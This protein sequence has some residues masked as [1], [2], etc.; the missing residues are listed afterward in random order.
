MQILISG[1]CTKLLSQLHVTLQNNT[2]VSI[3]LLIQ[4]TRNYILKMSTIRQLI[5]QCSTPFGNNCIKIF[6][7]TTHHYVVPLDREW[8]DQLQMANQATQS[9]PSGTF[10][11]HIFKWNRLSIL[12]KPVYRSQ[13]RL[14]KL[15]HIINAYYVEMALYLNAA[16]Q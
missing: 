4:V 3:L 10:N 12:R 14:L 15:Y 9:Q 7:T 1:E 8:C 11:L 16:I 6:F 2:K 13:Q 5:A